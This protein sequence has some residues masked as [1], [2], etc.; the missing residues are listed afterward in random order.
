MQSEHKCTMLLT[1]NANF[2][3]KCVVLVLTCIIVLCLTL[4]MFIGTS[5]KEEAK[6]FYEVVKVANARLALAH[7]SCYQDWVA[8]V[9]THPGGHLLAW[10]EDV[11]FRF[12]GA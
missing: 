3:K 2:G 8:G 10:V 7:S 4:S 11:G 1:R 9:A 12:A 6:F 5:G